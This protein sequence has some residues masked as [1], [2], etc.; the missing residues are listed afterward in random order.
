MEGNRNS[1]SERVDDSPEVAAIHSCN[2]DGRWQHDS[3]DDSQSPA[4]A[5]H[6]DEDHSSLSQRPDDDIDVQA[7]LVRDC[8]SVC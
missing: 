4:G 1:Y 3:C 5:D 8:R 6:E 7:N 2:D